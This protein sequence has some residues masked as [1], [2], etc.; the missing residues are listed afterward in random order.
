MISHYFGTSYRWPAIANDIGYP[1]IGA[2]YNTY[3]GYLYTDFGSIGCILY[4][5]AWSFLVYSVMK[6]R[7]LKI[8]SIFLFAY[9]LHYYATGNFVIGRLEYVRV[10]TTIIIYLVIRVIER[11]P[12]VRRLFTAKLVVGKRGAPR[13]FTSLRSTSID[14]NNIS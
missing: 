3:L 9:Y 2:V 14:D 1:P 6:K 7:P 4:T 12:L 13:T 8:S 10:V 11:S 5:A